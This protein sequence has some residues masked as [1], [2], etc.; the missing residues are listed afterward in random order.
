[1]EEN[2]F[3]VTGGCGFI[4]SNFINNHFILYP[5]SYFVNIDT[6]YN[7]SREDNIH[8]LVSE[9]SRYI[10]V[11]GNICDYDLVMHILKT[12]EID[13]VIHFAGRNTIADSP[14]DSW[15][16]IQ[17]NIIGTHTLLEACKRHNY[18][19]KFIYI[20]TDKVYGETQTEN[21]NKYSEQWVVCPTNPHAVSKASAELLVTSYY[22][23]YNLP[24]IITRLNNVYGLNQSPHKMIPTF[25]SLLKQNKKIK[26]RGDGSNVR[27]FSHIYDVTNAIDIII[28]H[29]IVGDIYNL[30][31]QQDECSILDIAKGL[32]LLMVSD[33][34]K[35]A[36]DFEPYI[37]FTEDTKNH[38]KRYFSRN[39]KLQKLGWRPEIPLIDGLVEM[40]KK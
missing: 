6:L 39:D 11:E 17:D 12:Y 9:S 22:H 13:I 29:G 15:K 31:N 24:V 10:F 37:E 8:K 19:D 38:N 23:T 20:S 26:I 27:A 40:I 14:M 4:G 1:M 2:N 34:F 33:K 36:E 7:K 32:V 5:N 21:M 30:N 3:L 25:I 18:L 28:Q 35:S 16:Y